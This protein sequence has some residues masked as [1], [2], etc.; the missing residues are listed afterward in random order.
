MPIERFKGSAI[1]LPKDAE[2]GRYDQ[3]RGGIINTEY[4]S[5]NDSDLSLLVFPS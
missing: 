4:H 5:G 1:S 3:R 2:K